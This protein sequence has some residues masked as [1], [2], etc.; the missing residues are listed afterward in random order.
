VYHNFVIQV[1]RREALIAYLLERGVESKI[2]YPIPL[3]LMR[4]AR[5]FGYSEGDFPVTERQ[6][7]RILSLPIYPELT[8]P[9]VDYVCDAISAFYEA[10]Q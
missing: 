2:H 4:S 10:A 3:H 7:D 5:K 1:D 6:R 9:Q 8:D